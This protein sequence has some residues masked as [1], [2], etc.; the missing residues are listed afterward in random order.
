MI[1]LL[2][3]DAKQ[4]YSYARRNTRLLKWAALFAVSIAG[5]GF[6][7]AGGLF[8]INQSINNTA[9]LNAK[10]QQSLKDQKMEETQKQ[11]QDIAGNLKLAVQVLSKEV[12]FSKLVRQIGANMPPNAILSALQISKTEGAIDLSALAKDYKTATQ[13]QVN[14]QDPANKIFEKTDI[15]NVSCSSRANPVYPCGITIR[16][17]FAK[18]NTFLF[19]NSNARDQP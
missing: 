13:V 8:Y 14:L 2:P 3:T 18:N 12:L 9:K 5:V 10:A 7:V 11:V 6:I 16:A 4:H 19:V 1:N 15:I 17:L